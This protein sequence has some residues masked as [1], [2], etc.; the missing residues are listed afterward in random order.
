MLRTLQH[1]ARS[2]VALMRIVLK[3]LHVLRTILLLVTNAFVM[4]STFPRAVRTALRWFALRG[5]APILVSVR[6]VMRIIAV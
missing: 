2:Q 6:R 3:D 1:H 4:M 5:R